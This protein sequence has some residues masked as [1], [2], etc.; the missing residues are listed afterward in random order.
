M[1]LAGLAHPAAGFPDFVAHPLGDSLAGIGTFQELLSPVDLDGDG[2]Q[3]FFSGAGGMRGG[4]VPRNLPVPAFRAGG[5][6]PVDAAGRTI[7][8]PRA[9]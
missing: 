9:E 5:A 2:D 3:D 4:R 6:G 8:A 1:L 7:R